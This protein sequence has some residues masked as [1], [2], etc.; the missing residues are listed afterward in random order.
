MRNVIGGLA[1]VLVCDKERIE[2]RE[3]WNRQLSNIPS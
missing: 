2:G 1:G 3:S